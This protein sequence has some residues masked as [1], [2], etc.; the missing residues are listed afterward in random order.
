MLEELPEE[1]VIHVLELC[2]VEDVLAVRSVCRRLARIGGDRLLWKNTLCVRGGLRVEGVETPLEGMELYGAA[3]RA[4]R[5]RW[6]APVGQEEGGV[7]LNQRS[8]DNGGVC[9]GHVR[10]IWTVDVGAE[11]GVV[12]TGGRDSRIRVWE[13]NGGQLECVATLA[14]HEK[15]INASWLD[16]DGVEKTYFSGSTDGTVRVWDLNAASL[17][18]AACVGVVDVGHSVLAL[19]RHLPSDTTAAGLHDGSIRVLDV[20]AGV[21]IGDAGSGALAQGAILSTDVAMESGTIVSGSHGGVVA[22]WDPR[23]Q[24]CVDY[25]S[26][27]STE[28][29]HVLYGMDP[30]YTHVGAYN[31]KA[32]TYDR[33]AVGHGPVVTMEEHAGPVSSLVRVPN[34]ARVVTGSYDGLVIG[35]DGV[36]GQVEYVCDGHDDWVRAVVANDLCVVS[37]DQQGVVSVWDASSGAYCHSFAASTSHPCLVMAQSRSLLAYAVKS[38]LTVVDMAPSSLQ[39]GGP[40]QLKPGRVRQDDVDEIDTP[41]RHVRPRPMRGGEEDEYEY[42]DD[43][44]WDQINHC[45]SSF[46]SWIV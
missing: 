20:A 35:W 5:K 32:Y 46:V 28:I 10:D 37:A 40:S 13:I 9:G 16:Q 42:E 34:S 30:M 22:W 29:L 24:T 1:L 25:V 17:H 27:A 39:P 7:V 45:L 3:Q 15:K 41:V 19:S 44:V 8:D 6:Q 38:T 33:R 31:G 43:D 26:L 2:E 21:E 18:T 12:V 23:S 36:T 14:G 11:T 4:L